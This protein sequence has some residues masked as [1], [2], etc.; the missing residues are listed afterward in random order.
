MPPK[1]A[2]VADVRL[3]EK[4]KKEFK[5]LCDAFDMTPDD[6]SASVDRVKEHV[7]KPV[8]DGK[9]PLFCAV[10]SAAQDFSLV[11]ALLSLKDV[12]VDVDAPSDPLGDTPLI[13]ALKSGRD[14]LVDV[15]LRAG[16]DPSKVNDSGVSALHIAAMDCDRA[17]VFE[18][19]L[20]AGSKAGGR[21]KTA[22][23][24]DTTLLHL[25]AAEGCTDQLR[26]LL[27]TYP[28]LASA[29]DNVCLAPCSH[30]LLFNTD[31]LFLIR[32]T[33]GI[34]HSAPP[35]VR[36]R[37]FALRQ[38]AAQSL[39]QRRRRRLRGQHANASRAGF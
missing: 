15:L 11:Q 16:A 12:P 32:A 33:A 30:P 23:A 34:P 8:I 13:S 29:P 26:L 17:A 18:S 24:A 4:V 2:R 36:G 39:C 27:Q 37:R 19:V 14:D 21:V 20:R 31:F 28:E 1:L 22:S 10:E 25:A 3:T 35:G 7:N 38:G 5:K 6:L 9:T